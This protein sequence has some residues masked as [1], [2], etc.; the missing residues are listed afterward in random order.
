MLKTITLSRN[1][2][3]QCNF[4]FLTTGCGARVRLVGLIG[5]FSFFGGE[6]GW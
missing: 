6:G 4:P 3:Q 1:P 5:F 2:L